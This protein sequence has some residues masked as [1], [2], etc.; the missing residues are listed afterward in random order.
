MSKD[1]FIRL[2]GKVIELL[3]KSKF[4]V[5]LDNNGVKIR[6]TLS[7]KM[8]KNSIIIVLGDR[9]SVEIS[10]YDLTQGRIT[11]RYKN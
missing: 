7:G 1:D 8:R 3:P 6:A 9:V 2:E 5:L 11:Y 4:T 10:P